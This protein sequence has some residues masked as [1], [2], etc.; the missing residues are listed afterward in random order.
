MS[1]A[2]RILE[3]D[4]IQALTLRATARAA[5]VSHAAPASHFGDLTGL[6][7]ELAAL[8]Y[9]RFGKAVFEAM[10]AAGED[11]RARMKAMGRAYVGFA[12]KHPGLF[13]LMY[14]SERLDPARPALRDAIAEARSALRA[15]ASARAQE[16]PLPP[17]QT[18]AQSAALWALVH[19]FAVLLIDGRLSALIASL[20]GEE[21]ADTLLEAVLAT[22]RVGE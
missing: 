17:L 9:R 12:R 7:S 3:R 8:G 10:E 2:E 19:G 16:Q 5:G 11:P 13:S 1:A 15:A 21:G 6:L 20:P 22:A 18:A 14:R 4:G